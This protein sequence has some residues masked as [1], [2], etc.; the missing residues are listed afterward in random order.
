MAISD[1]E[2]AFLLHLMEKLYK[3]PKIQ[4]PAF[5]EVNIAKLL[6]LS[7]RNNFG[8]YTSKILYEKYGDKLSESIRSKLG[9]II[10]QCETLLSDLHNTGAVLDSCL[11]DYILH[12]TYRG[13]SRIPSDIDTLVPDLDAAS[14]KLQ[15]RGMKIKEYEGHAI[16]LVDNNG[17]KVH[18]HK[19]IFWANS[20]FFDKE[21]IFRNFRT[22]NIWG[23][24]AKIPG[25]TADFLIHLAHINF[26]PLHFTLSDF[27][28]LCK[29]APFVNWETLLRQ[30]EKYN[31]EQSFMHTL[32]LICKYE[33]ALYAPPHPFDSITKKHVSKNDAVIVFPK[34]LPRTMIVLGF[35]EKKAFSYLL[36]KLSKAVQILATGDTYQSY[37]QPPEFR[38]ICKAL[39]NVEIE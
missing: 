25:Y 24:H 26:E 16:M 12:K 31:W 21:F 23:L 35:F 27:L 20:I 6:R 30:V 32:S 7:A 14:D 10:V 9:K 17:V 3:M 28:Y 8:Y 38:L 1:V 2:T 19:E 18:L 4:R 34:N 11:D 13:Y 5:K 39:N 37:Y 29:I 22:V 15:S 33:R 36:S